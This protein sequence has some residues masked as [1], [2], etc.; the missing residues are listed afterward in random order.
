MHF[1]PERS[2]LIN[3]N[4]NVEICDNWQAWAKKQN[5]NFIFIQYFMLEIFEKSENA[6]I[7]FTK[8]VN[9]DEKIFM[10]AILSS[11]YILG[12][13][14][15]KKDLHQESTKHFSAFSDINI[16]SYSDKIANDLALFYFYILVK[17]I[18]QSKLNLNALERIVNLSIQTEFQINLLTANFEFFAKPE[19]INFYEQILKKFIIKICSFKI[20]NECLKY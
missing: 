15:G 8:Y 17:D 12:L 7:I 16:Q 13:L 20:L 5:P 10:H 3:K 2:L 1:K 9:E 11:Q 18:S 6:D 19:N 4:Q 14:F